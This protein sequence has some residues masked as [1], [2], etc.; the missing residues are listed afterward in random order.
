MNHDRNIRN[1]DKRT[2][3]DTSKSAY[4]PSSSPSESSKNR[5]INNRPAWQNGSRYEDYKPANFNNENT[6]RQFVIKVT[7]C[8]Y[9]AT[10]APRAMPIKSQ[11]ELPHLFFPIGLPSELPG[12]I[13]ALYD[14]GAA[15][16]T[17]YLAYHQHIHR[18]APDLV[19][20]YESFDG[21]EPFD[22]IRLTGAICDPAAYSSHTHGVL[23]AIIRYNTPFVD[24]VTLE[25][26]ILSFAL[27]KDMTVNA[28]VGI[29]FIRQLRLT[30]DFDPE[31]IV[32]HTLRKYFPLKF[33]ETS[34]FTPIVTPIS[35]DASTPSAIAAHIALVTPITPATI[36]SILQASMNYYLPRSK[37]HDSKLDHTISSGVNE[38]SIVPFGHPPPVQPSPDQSELLKL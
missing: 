37:S 32:S 34:L 4:I 30:L 36:P 31:T 14:T 11:N 12:E 33:L 16:N 17:G 26:I 13:S 27:G 6:K 21:P 23:S 38:R 19:H 35:A 20:S 22:P 5:T 18:L 3:P 25:P 7:A 10:R 29:P 1:P 9:N 2:R 15:L 24:D 8:T 28:I